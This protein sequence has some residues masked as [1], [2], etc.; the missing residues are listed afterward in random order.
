MSIK[1]DIFA[2]NDL[3][4]K[5]ITVPEWGDMTIHLKQLSVQDR[6]D[7]A[8]YTNACQ[9]QGINP[10]ASFFATLMICDPDT[11]KRVFTTKDDERK[12]AEKSATVLD[13]IVMIG[14]DHS[15]LTENSDDEDEEVD[16]EGN[17]YPTLSGN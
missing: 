17:D 1:Q 6:Q 14:L 16:E 10:A 5:E 8:K 12:L 4:I 3:S 9:T 2:T 15:N 13:R 11:G 7:F